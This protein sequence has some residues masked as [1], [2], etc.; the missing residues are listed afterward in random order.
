MTNATHPC[1]VLLYINVGNG[2]R[3]VPQNAPR[4]S[5]HSSEMPPHLIHPVGAIHESPGYLRFRK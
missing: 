3:A 1:G 4:R 5:P 2:P